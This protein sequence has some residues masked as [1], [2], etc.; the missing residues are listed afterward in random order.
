MTYELFYWPGLQGRGEFVRL[1][2]EDAGATYVDVAREPGG[3]KRLIAALANGIEDVRPFAP[4]FLRAGKTVIAQT[5]NVTRWLAERHGLAPSTDHGAAFAATIAL[6]VADLVKEAHDTHHPVWAD[7]AYEK[8]KAAA[9]HA[10]EGFR[11]SRMPKFLGW[12]ESVLQDNGKVLVGR[13]VTY[14]DLAVFQVV[15]GLQYAFPKAMKKQHAKLKRVLALRD[16]IAKRPKLAAYLAS[17][18]RIP[19]NETGIFRHYPELDG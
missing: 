3:M 14:A 16:A 18:R 7:V 11:K 5:A 2:L 4:P 12:I 15:E 10:A 8:Q 9:R 6:T 13:S 17:D 1:V 19:F